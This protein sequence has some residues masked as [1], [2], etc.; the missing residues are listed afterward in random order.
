MNERNLDLA[1]LQRQLADILDRL[2]TA[3]ETAQTTDAVRALAREIGEVNHRITMVG[4]LQFKQQSEKI[5]AAVEKVS[6][7]KKTIDAAIANIE[8]LNA[9]LKTISS[10]LALVDKAIDV[11]KLF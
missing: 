11:A 6:A 2:I 10:F 7:E 1:D 3:Q 5:R 8:K 4:Q 9:F